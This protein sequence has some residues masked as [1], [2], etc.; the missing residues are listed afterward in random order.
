MPGCIFYDVPGINIV[1]CP[2]QDKTP[3]GYPE[4]SADN[5]PDQDK[6]TGLIF[7]I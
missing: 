1:D 4:I 7:S 6:S 2:N 3:G 5:C